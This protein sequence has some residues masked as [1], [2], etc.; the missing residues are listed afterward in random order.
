[1]QYCFRNQRRS[2]TNGRHKRQTRNWSTNSTYSASLQEQQ[3]TLLYIYTFFFVPFFQLG[4]N[5]RFLSDSLVFDSG[6]TCELSTI[7]PLQLH[8]LRR[9]T[10][11]SVTSCDILWLRDT[12][13]QYS[14]QCNIKPSCSWRRQGRLI[15]SSFWPNTR[16]TTRISLHWSPFRVIGDYVKVQFKGACLPCAF[17]P[18]MTR[19]NSIQYKSNKYMYMMLF[20]WRTMQSAQTSESACDKKCCHLA[21]VHGRNWG[22]SESD[23]KGV[24]AL[25][26]QLHGIIG[27][28]G[29][30][31]FFVSS[32][33]LCIWLNYGS[34]VFSH[35]EGHW[36]SDVS[37][38]VIFRI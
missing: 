4:E 31:Y 28:F 30:L 2:T 24:L 6:W 35:L 29:L 32:L 19:T 26:K 15:D 27:V 9:I 22:V 1:M 36:I 17:S 13:T 25:S 7:V 34:S 3:H 16:N 18:W 8:L 23:S 5:V 10:K 38:N 37:L 11:I 21:C 12:G 20:V 33:N 14:V